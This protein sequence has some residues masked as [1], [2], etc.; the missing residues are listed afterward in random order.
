[1]TELELLD[2]LVIIFLV[3]LRYHHSVN[4]ILCYIVTVPFYIP[5]SSAQ[6]L[7]ILYILSYTCYFLLVVIPLGIK[8]YF[9]IFIFIFLIISDAEYLFVMF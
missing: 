6:S 2:Y 1:M 8:W 7:Q 9:V 5:N 3:F 4:S